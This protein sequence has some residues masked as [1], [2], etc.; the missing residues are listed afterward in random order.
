MN[1]STQLGI[2]LVF[3]GGAQGLFFALVLSG[4]QGRRSAS[5]RILV[6]LL[7]MVSVGMFSIAGLALNPGHFMS[8]I[9]RLA[10][11]LGTGSVPLLYLYVKTL[12]TAEFNLSLSSLWHFTPILFGAFFLLL[13]GRPEYDLSNMFNL[14]PSDHV[15]MIRL[16]WIVYALPYLYGMY[17]LLKT[18]ATHMVTMF[19]LTGV[20][21][22][23]MLYKMSVYVWVKTL[24]IAS[25][26]YW[27]TSIIL[28]LVPGFPETGIGIT[29]LV[30]MLIYGVGFIGVLKPELFCFPGKPDEQRDEYS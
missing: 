13:F 25:S 23:G 10:I 29:L 1:T 6:S 24:L 18:H 3:M 16:I 28:F 8:R 19:Q 20:L 17:R 11:L 7:I 9:L 4:L 26:I 30:T 14:F 27:I 2:H 21:D 22:Q 5:N 12:M 15:A